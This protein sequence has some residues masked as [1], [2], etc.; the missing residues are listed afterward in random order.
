MDLS[1]STWTEPPLLVAEEA[2]PSPT[3]ERLWY[4]WPSR[5]FHLYMFYERQTC[6]T[7]WLPEGYMQ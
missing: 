5:Y 7:C 1:R 3:I 2:P 6:R 4:L